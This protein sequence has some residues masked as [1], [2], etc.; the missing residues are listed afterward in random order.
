LPANA[1]FF[2]AKNIAAGV[3][4]SDLMPLRKFAHLALLAHLIIEQAYS[5]L[6][7]T[8]LAP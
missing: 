4:H 7:S 8:A 6:A 5:S 3:L 1:G 2:V